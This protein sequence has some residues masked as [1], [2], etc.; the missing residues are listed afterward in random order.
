MRIALLLPLVGS[1]HAGEIEGTVWYDARGEVAWV[2]GPAARDS[3]PP[4]VP[5]W[6][7]REERRDRALRGGFR[8]RSRWTSAWPVWGYGG[9]YWISHA[10][11]HR[12]SGGFFR[13]RSFPSSSFHW[14]RPSGGLRVI[15]R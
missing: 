11:R 2:D 4:F 9:G 15:I 8:P 7:A 5:Q 1:L 6:V 14:T 10:P 3:R 13:C 12:A